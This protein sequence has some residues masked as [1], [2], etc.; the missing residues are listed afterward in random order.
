MAVASRLNN[1]SLYI[2][3]EY[4]GLDLRKKGSR[5]VVAPRKRRKVKLKEGILSRAIFPNT[6]IPPPETA[7]NSTKKSI[8][9]L[10]DLLFT[11]QLYGVFGQLARV[12]WYE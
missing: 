8:V 12:E 4:L 5:T 9:I 2:S 11:W 10:E 6:D 7:D 1:S 3:D